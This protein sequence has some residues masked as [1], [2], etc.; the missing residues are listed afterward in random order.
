ML[1]HLLWAAVIAIAGTACSISAQEVG[2]E[3]VP[4]PAIEDPVLSPDELARRLREA[5]HRLEQLESL[6]ED[7]YPDVPP[8]P[9]SLT[10]DIIQRLSTLESDRDD[11]LKKKQGDASKPT[12]KWTGRLHTD[13]WAFPNPSMGEDAFETGDAFDEVD[14]R[15]LFRR[16]RIGV[17]GD[18]PDF[19]LYKLEVDFNNPAAPQLKDNYVGWKDVPFFQT[20]LFGNQKRPYGLDHINSSRYNV[21]LERPAVVEAI[22]Q[23]ARR[24]GL[25]A[26]GFSDDLKYNW[27]FGGYMGRDMQNLGTVTATPDSQDY[28]AEFAARLAR[29]LFIG[30]LARHR[31]DFWSRRLSGGRHRR[32]P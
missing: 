24:F 8:P 9:P 22:N 10:D 2:S 28:Q 26:Y 1:R 27:R 16:I 12:M 4:A 32:S 18:I 15:F 11:A 20:V 13:Y 5:E 17:Q 30:A 19:M 31:S 14:D 29:T 25:A 3:L 7:D 23:D 6:T 21:F